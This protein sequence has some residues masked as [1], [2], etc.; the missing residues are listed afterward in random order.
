SSTPVHVE[1]IAYKDGVARVRRDAITPIPA[2]SVGKLLLPLNYLCDGSA[3]ADA[4]AEGGVGSSCP[5]NF[6][7]VEGECAS[8]V[9]RPVAVSEGAIDGGSVTSADG[10]VSGGCFDA[11]ACFESARRVSLDASSCTLTVSNDVDPAGLNVALQFPPGGPGVCG[12]KACYVVLA[13]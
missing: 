6:T 5:K 3:T 2:D 7:C 9:V 10:G 11:L 4:G 13:R 12:D 1:G 8:A